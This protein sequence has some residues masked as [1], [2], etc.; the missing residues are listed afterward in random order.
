ML[1][2]TDAGRALLADGMTRSMRGVTF[3][4]IAL[5]SGRRAQSGTPEGDDSRTA[6]RNE[7]DR[8]VPVGETAIAGRINLCAE[9]M[10]GGS[11]S[12][13]EIGLYGQHD[14]D[15]AMLVAYEALEVGDAPWT[16]LAGGL[17]VM[18]AVTLDVVT[19]AGA[20]SVMPT[21]TA[22]FEGASSFL[23]LTDT[24]ATYANHARSLVLVNGAGTGVEFIKMAPGEKRY[25]APGNFNYVWP[26]AATKA[27]VVLQGGGG[28]GGGGT[29]HPTN[30]GSNGADGGQTSVSRAAQTVV[31]AGGRGGR[32]R[33]TGS[34]LCTVDRRAGGNGGNGGSIL[35][36]NV[37]SG[38]GE[39]GR[40]G[41]LTVGEITGLSVGDV[42]NV[43]VGAPGAAGTMF[44]PQSENPIYASPGG[45]GSVLIV[46]VYV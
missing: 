13:T 42:L 5:G 33:N 36:S 46:P 1:R 37:V 29:S 38:N 3:T 4:H 14:T 12:L 9:R 21:L 26:F 40:S 22:R 32:K 2:L 41:D 20:V 31:A 39:P 16:E 15:P 34:A 27:R 44:R 24:P 6:L 11:Y 45:P 43:V 30:L 25:T 17:L 18:I 28:G 8:L 23:D 7:R 19:G 35:R 10:G